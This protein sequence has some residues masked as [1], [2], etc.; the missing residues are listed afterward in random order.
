MGFLNLL[1]LCVILYIGFG[2]LSFYL[3][4]DIDISACA[5]AILFLVVTIFSVVA[6]IG[7][8]IQIIEQKESATLLDV[9][10]FIGIVLFVLSL[11]LAIF[12]CSSEKTASLTLGVI[13]LV[14]IIGPMILKVLVCI[15]FTTL[16]FFGS[17][18]WCF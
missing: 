1:S 17:S 4:L 6:G 16:P 5:W 9:I 2:V 13:G 3:D 7:R 18:G 12:D 10:L 11:V 15:I 14:L 8:F